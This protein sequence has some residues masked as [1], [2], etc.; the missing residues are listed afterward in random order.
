M[1]NFSI[2]RNASLNEI[3]SRC[4]FSRSNLASRYTRNNGD[5]RL[6]SRVEITLRQPESWV[7]VS[8]YIRHT[9]IIRNARALGIRIERRTPTS[10]YS[11]ESETN[12]ES[13]IFY[14]KSS[15]ESYT[16][17]SSLFSPLAHWWLTGL[18]HL[19][20]TI[21]LTNNIPGIVLYR[22]S[23]FQPFSCWSFTTT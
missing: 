13:I 18:Q 19:Q 22:A 16:V 14:E 21:F 12:N 9:L 11:K 10:L 7:K 1:S 6:E 8:Q 23:Y 2:N 20:W 5:V 3:R 15:S 17:V 4:W